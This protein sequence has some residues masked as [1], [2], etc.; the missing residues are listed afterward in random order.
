[1]IQIQF[2][3]AH[4]SAHRAVSESWLASLLDEEQMFLFKN[5]VLVWMEV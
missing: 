4:I 1:M 2:M 5:I 3:V